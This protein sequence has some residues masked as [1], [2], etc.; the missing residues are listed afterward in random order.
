MTIAPTSL[1][2]RPVQQRSTQRVERMLSACAELVSELGYDGV[3]TT[4]IAERA[5]VAVGSLYQFFPDKKAVVAE[6]TRRNL[7]DFLVRVREQLATSTPGDWWG[8]VDT[9]FD[10]YVAMHRT[11]P[12]FSRL[13]FGDAVDLQL[14]DERKEN[15]ALI[16]DG[17]TRL[18]AP[19]FQI[20]ADRLRLPLAVAIEAADAVLNLAFR[21]DPIGDGHVVDEAKAMIRGYLSAR[22]NPATE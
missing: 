7:D 18:L 6:L 15:N 10:V 1:R 11:V 14:L 20:A 19:R 5:G 9:V 17:L 22:L 2:R 16:T 12:G 8:A 21:R 13:H 4:L 3:T